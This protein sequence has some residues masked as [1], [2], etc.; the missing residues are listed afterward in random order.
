LGVGPALLR[1]TYLLQLPHLPRA[2]RAFWVAV[3]AAAVIG[4]ALLMLHLVAAVSQLGWPQRRRDGAPILLAVA[5]AAVYVA[6]GAL[7]VFLDR[8]LFWLLPP[9]GL[10]VAAA[11]S[12]DSRRGP[13][14]PTFIVSAVLVVMYGLFSVLATRD[15]LAWN[16]VRWEALEG[17]TSSLGVPPSQID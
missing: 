12:S 2:P 3:T 1:D 8:Y 5:A 13:G 10:G 11:A 4:A 15:Y 9:L 17:L 6:A 7:A 16:R 14:W